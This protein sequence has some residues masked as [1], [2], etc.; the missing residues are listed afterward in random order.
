MATGK[1][2]DDG[3]GF[4]TDLESVEIAQSAHRGDELWELRTI[5]TASND[6]LIDGSSLCC[7]AQLDHRAEAMICVILAGLPI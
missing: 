4:F 1:A 3:G 5:G 2:A 7:V 6:L